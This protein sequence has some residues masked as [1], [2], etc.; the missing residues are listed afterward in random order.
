MLDLCTGS[1][2][3]GLTLAAERSGLKVDLTDLS[4]EALAVARRNAEAFEVTDRVRLLEGDLFAPIE[5]DARYSLIACN[6]PYIPEAE[7]PELMPEVRDHEPRE[8]LVSGPSGFEVLRRLA[9]QAG[10]FLG[11]DGVLLVEVGAGQAP[12]FEKMLAEQPWVAETARHEDLG[13]VE[14]VVE[15]RRANA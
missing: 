10:D 11:S 7:I 13:G 14:R 12:D 3:I 15:A 9:A 8:A 4:A 5:P 1:G 6:P 2:A